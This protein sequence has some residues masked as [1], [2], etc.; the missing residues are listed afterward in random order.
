MEGLNGKKILVT[1]GTGLVG[2]H[3]IEM[4]LTKGAR[5]VVLTRSLDPQ[6]YF[7]TAGLDTQVVLRYGDIL[8]RRVFSDLLPRYGIDTIFHLAAQPIVTTAYDQPYSTLNTNIMGTVQVLEAARLYCGIRRIIVASSDKAYGKSGKK[9]RE[10][11]PLVGDHPYEVSK[12]AADLVA[13]SYARTYGLPVTVARFGNIYGEG[14]LNLSRIIP[15]I[16]SSLIRG[17]ELILRSDGSLTRDYIYVGDVARGYVML[18]EYDG[19]LSGEA[20]NFGSSDTYTVLELIRKIET[21]LG[22]TIRYRI[23]NNQKNEIPYQSLDFRK[24]TGVT[25]WEPTHTLDTTVPKL[26]RWYEGIWKTI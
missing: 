14:D 1:G 9:Y 3:V 4:L 19:D 2:S 22:K 20:F 13:R 15:G 18:V 8:D 5:V 12:S 6:S 17:E 11:D 21:I 10:S 16:M 26:Y 24:I 7:V 23:D 25:G